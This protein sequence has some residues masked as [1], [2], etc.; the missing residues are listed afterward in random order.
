MFKK[1]E[2]IM[3]SEQTLVGRYELGI[4]KCLTWS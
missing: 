2:N 4:S 3:Q 1:L